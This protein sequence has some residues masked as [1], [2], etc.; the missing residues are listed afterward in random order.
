MRRWA[1]RPGETIQM[2]GTIICQLE[3]WGYNEPRRINEAAWFQVPLGGWQHEKNIL[4]YQTAAGP[5]FNILL[6]HMHHLIINCNGRDV[7]V[8]LKPAL[9]GKGVGFF[10]LMEKHVPLLF[11]DIEII[12]HRMWASKWDVCHKCPYSCA[13]QMFVVCCENFLAIINSKLNERRRRRRVDGKNKAWKLSFWK[14]KETTVCFMNIL[15]LKQ[16]R[17]FCSWEK[18][19]KIL[20]LFGH[21]RSA[22]STAWGSVL[23]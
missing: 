11:G 21:E 3:T 15:N 9:K 6:F 22:C 18:K 13:H 7:K 2:T 23:L 20:S 12:I 16:F 10:L 14:E 5:L 4:F 8:I 19:K 17:T 1:I